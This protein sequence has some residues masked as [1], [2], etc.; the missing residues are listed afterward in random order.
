MEKNKRQDLKCV[1]VGLT[2]N[3]WRC[4]GYVARLKN[5]RCNRRKLEWRTYEAPTIKGRPQRRWIDELVVRA[6]IV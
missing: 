3:K 1:S 5:G 4:V 2:S 6:G